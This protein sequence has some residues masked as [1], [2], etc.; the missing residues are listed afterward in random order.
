MPPVTVIRARAPGSLWAGATRR[1]LLDARVGTRARLTQRA[2]SADLGRAS[3]GNVY[4]RRKARKHGTGTCLSCPTST[5]G[6][7]A[8]G[9]ALGISRVSSPGHR[10]GAR[11]RRFKETTIRCLTITHPRASPPHDDDETEGPDRKLRRVARLRSRRMRLS[12]CKRTRPTPSPTWRPSSRCSS[13][14]ASWSRGRPSR[15]RARAR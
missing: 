9:R 15:R 14:S 7:L 12:Q 2:G 10:H 4:R 8:A 11:R 13:C 6:C 1:G 5:V 3:R